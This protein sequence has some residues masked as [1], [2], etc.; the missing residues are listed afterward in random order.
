MT[1]GAESWAMKVDVLRRLQ[2]TEM[3]M[4][5]RMCWKT[6]NDKVRSEKMR[7]VTGVEEIRQFLRERSL[8]W[9]GHV[10]NE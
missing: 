6:L 1:Y 10:E 2:T 8:R 5:W 4:L 7:E 3:R 9:F